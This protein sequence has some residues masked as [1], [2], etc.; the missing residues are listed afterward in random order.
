MSDIFN[1]VNLIITL[2]K[3]NNHLTEFIN[4]FLKKIIA[5]LIIRTLI[6]NPF[7]SL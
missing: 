1:I 3:I 6:R 5:F 4:T 2:L 7:Q